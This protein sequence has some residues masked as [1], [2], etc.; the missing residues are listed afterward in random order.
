RDLLFMGYRY[1]PSRCWALLR[2]AHSRSPTKARRGPVACSSE[3]SRSHGKRQDRDGPGPGCDLPLSGWLFGEVFVG[4]LDGDGAL[5]PGGGDAF[6]GPVA[7]V[8]GGEDAG[9]A[10]LQEQRGA[11]Q[12]PAGGGAGGG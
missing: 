9:E 2:D 6:D 8:P 7:H 10:G 3:G 4:E 11:R 5:A 1:L 12:R